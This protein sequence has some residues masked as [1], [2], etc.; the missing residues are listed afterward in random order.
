LHFIGVEV[1]AVN[2]LEATLRDLLQMYRSALV[3]G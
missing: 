3:Q 1:F 2:L